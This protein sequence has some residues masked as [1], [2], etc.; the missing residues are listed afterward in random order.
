MGRGRHAASTVIDPVCH[1][2]D[3]RAVRRGGPDETVVGPMAMARLHLDVTANGP[4]PTMIVRDR[5]PTGSKV[6]RTP[7]APS[8]PT[9]AVPSAPSGP[10]GA[11]GFAMARGRT[12]ARQTRTP[13]VAGWAGLLQR[14]RDTPG[15]LGSPTGKGRQGEG[16]PERLGSLGHV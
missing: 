12:Q 1:M 4:L 15:H 13:R 10:S 7:K 6:P 5:P 2:A 8:S 14:E 16:S 9:P 11:K 3:R